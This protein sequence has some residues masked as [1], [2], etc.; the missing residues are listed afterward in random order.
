MRKLDK[1]IASLVIA[2]LLL[3]IAWLTQPPKGINNQ[4]PITNNQT[5]TTALNAATSTIAFNATSTNAFVVKA[6]DGDTLTVKLDGSTNQVKVRLL[7]VNTPET[8]DPRKTVECFGK[9]ASAYAHSK[10]DGRRIRLD[11]DPQADEIDKYGR[12]LRNVILEDGT[13]F[14]AALVRDG[15]A[16]AYLSFPLNKQRKAQLKQLEN[17]AR[18]AQRGLWATSTCSGKL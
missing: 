4:A 14:N 2:G 10:V 1:R 11:A 12:L 5:T 6:V 18:I 8:V 9:E 17:E 7:G 15:Y 16:Y 3:L 13:D